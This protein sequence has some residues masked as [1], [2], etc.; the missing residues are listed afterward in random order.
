[1]NTYYFTFG[2]SHPLRDYWIEITAPSGKL[3]RERMV[4]S[5]GTKWASQYEDADWK[6]ENFPGGRAGAILEVL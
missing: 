2:Q 5:F 4:E 1:M 6:P 3:A